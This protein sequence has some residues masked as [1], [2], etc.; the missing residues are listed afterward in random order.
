M[1]SELHSDMQRIAEMTI[2]PIFLTGCKVTELSRT[3]P[4]RR[5]W[6]DRGYVKLREFGGTLRDKTIPSQ[7]ERKV[8][9]SK[10]VTTKD[11]KSDSTIEREDT[12]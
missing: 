10:G 11:C 1:C 9:R 5:T 8:F 3:D 2:P 12:L 7:V 6:I 4:R